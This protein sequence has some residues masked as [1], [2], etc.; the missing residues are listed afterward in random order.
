MDC[1]ALSKYI[2]SI[3]YIY[4]S[5]LKR[6]ILDD[7]FRSTYLVY[8]IYTSKVWRVQWKMLSL[9]FC[10]SYCTRL[11]L[12]T[13]LSHNAELY[14]TCFILQ[15]PKI[16]TLSVAI[17][18]VRVIV[19]DLYCWCKITYRNDLFYPFYTA[20]ATQQCHNLIVTRRW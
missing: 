10:Q 16:C 2:S 11:V 17:Y 4:F 8:C 9:N 14:C 15:E 7:F 18:F 1:T 19:L 5:I 3:L 6:V 12:Q 20:K 13:Q